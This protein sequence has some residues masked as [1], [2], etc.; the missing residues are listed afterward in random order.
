MFVIEA[1]SASPG[2]VARTSIWPTWMRITATQPHERHVALVGADQRVEIR[3]D[4]MPRRAQTWMR[5]PVGAIERVGRR[6]SIGT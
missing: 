3:V 2:S 4:R 6:H 1:I 5:K